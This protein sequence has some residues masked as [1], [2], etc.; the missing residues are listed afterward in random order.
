M[1]TYKM[2][3]KYG[4]IGILLVLFSYFLNYTKIIPLKYFGLIIPSYF[5]IIGLFLLFDALNIYLNKTSLIHKLRN[6]NHS[7][8]KLI[9]VGFG[10]GIVFE[11]YG[12]YISNLWYSYFQNWFLI[13]YLVHYFLGILVGYGLPA[14]MYFN[15]YFVISTLI[16]KK[17]YKNR[18]KISNN[19]FIV[20]LVIGSIFLF[21][22]LVLYRYSLVWPSVI[23]GLLFGFC[24]IGL[25]FI[26]EYFEH[27]LHQNT[28]LISLLQTRF[29][30]LF[31]L[32]IISVIVSISWECLN[33]LR[34]SWVYQN[35]PLMKFTILGLPVAI[36]IA[37]P[38][39]FVVYF[40]VYRVIFRNKDRIW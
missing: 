10:I 37:W 7:L 20:L 25:W 30:S 17:D 16:K 38:M 3:P 12:V 23:R 34:P 39:L 5:F 33:V 35:L 21:L 27:K 13:P 8:L 28:F 9:F 31:S 11:I 6:K 14:L 24:L 1:S 4:F 15:A 32:L 26:F 18:F 29:K 22:P 19:F 2:F 36:I 40:S